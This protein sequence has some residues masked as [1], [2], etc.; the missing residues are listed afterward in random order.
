MEGEGG[1]SAKD[2]EMFLG[3]WE[4]LQL[5]WGRGVVLRSHDLLRVAQGGSG[6]MPP[7]LKDWP[8]ASEHQPRASCW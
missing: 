1:L 7:P 3:R 4:C 8:D 6:F 2:G 5:D